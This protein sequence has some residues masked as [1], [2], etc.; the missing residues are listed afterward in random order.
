MGGGGAYQPWEQAYFALIV[1]LGAVLQATVFGSVAVLLASLDED[2][3]M[4]A[5]KMSKINMRMS[6]LNIPAETQDRVRTYYQKMW[7]TERSLTT[8]P[9]EFIDEVSKPLSA[10]IKMQLYHTLLE[11]VDFFKSAS[12]IVVEELVKCLENRLYLE[13]DVIMRKGEAGSW[14][15]F[16]TRGQVAILSPETGKVIRVMDPGEY[17]GE[18]ALL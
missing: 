17:L 18:M 6:Y 5:K 3:L 1:V 7:D 10:D 11:H 4:F 14:M 8:N 16:I 12:E 13:G 15:G 9:D 2:N